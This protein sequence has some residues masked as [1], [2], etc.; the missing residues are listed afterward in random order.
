M[1]DQSPAAR[2]NVAGD[3]YASETVEGQP[4]DEPAPLAAP[5]AA[6]LANGAAPADAIRVAG[7]PSFTADELAAALEAAQEAQPSLVAG[8][9]SDGREVQRAKGTGYSAM[10]DLAQKLTFAGGASAADSVDASR[11]AAEELFR[12]TLS[13]DHTRGEVAVIAPKWL[14]SPHRKHAGIFFAA[15]LENPQNA[16]TVVEATAA[17]ESGESLTLLLARDRLRGVEDSSRPLGVVGWIIDAPAKQV[18]GYTGQA[19]QAVWVGKLVPL[20]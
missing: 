18:D 11:Q 6:P 7:E 20:E 9:L 5:P 15:S 16:G 1:T 8:N 12:T 17:L 19:P 14:T 4:V 3:R 13:D 10:A 2:P